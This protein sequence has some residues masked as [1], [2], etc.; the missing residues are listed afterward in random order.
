MHQ[1]VRC[2][3]SWHWA[4]MSIHHRRPRSHRFP[5]LNQPSNLIVL[6]GSGT[7]GCHAWVHQH[8][9][10]AYANGWLV[11]GTKD[12]TDPLKVP[13][14]TKQHGLVLLDDEG[15]WTPCDAPDT[16]NSR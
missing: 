8:P 14:L 11:H 4:G 9:L 10:E 16:N 3:G 2:G 1:C 5:G 7:V 12:E 13:V 6:C 15:G